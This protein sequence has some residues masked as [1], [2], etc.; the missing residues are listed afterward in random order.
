M[1]FLF[2]SLDKRLRALRYICLQFE[3]VQMEIGSINSAVDEL[4][5]WRISHTVRGQVS[6]KIRTEC[7]ILSEINRGITLDIAS[8]S[9]TERV[10]SVNYLLLSTRKLLL[11]LKN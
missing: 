4:N 1:K 10:T 11:I 5:R 2:L 7:L 8:N 9:L 3:F 6:G